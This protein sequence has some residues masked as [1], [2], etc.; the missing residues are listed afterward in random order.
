MTGSQLTESIPKKREAAQ[1]YLK[2]VCFKKK[3]AKKMS[4]GI[5]RI[6]LL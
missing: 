2:K 1:H 4:V 5:L 6:S 3:P